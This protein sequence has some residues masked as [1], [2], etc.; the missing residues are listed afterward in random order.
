M[1]AILLALVLA[2]PPAA[3]DTLAGVVVDASGG[4]VPG[5][6]VTLTRN[7]ATRAVTTA[8]DGSWSAEPPAGSGVVQV[9]VNALGFAPAMQVVTLPAGTIRF[10]LRPAAIAEAI[11]VSAEA[12]ATR[13]AIESSV[14]SLDRASIATAPALRL[15]DQLRT[16]PGFSLFRRTS[17]AV[18]N[19]T[20]QGVTLRGL[21]ASGASRTLVM[22]DDV[23]LN[24]PFGMW[25]YW[26]RIPL[27]A[28]QRVDVMRGSSGDVHGNDALGGVIRLTTRTSR[29]AEAWLDAGSSGTGR[30]SGY[31]GFSRAAWN[32]GGALEHLTTNGYKVV[33]PE[34]RGPIDV[35]ADSSAASGY[36]WFGAARD[37]LQA[38][39][40]GGYFQEDRGNGTPAQVN[41]T[42]TRWGGATAHGFAA[43][44]VWE[45]RGDVS[46]TDYR[47]TFSAVLAGRASERLTSL[48][49][50][51]SSGGGGAVSWLRESG[52]AQMMFA[53]NSRVA[54]ADLDEAAFSLAGVL[55]PTVRTRAKQFGN[56]FIAQARFDLSRRVSI[57][58]GARA[59]RWQLEKLDDAAGENTLNFFSPRAGVSFHLTPDRTLRVAWLTGF[60]TP[61]M[62]ELYRGFRVGNTN[63]LANPA[64][65][66]ETSWGP[67]VAFTMRHQRWTARAIGYATRLE[68]AIYNRTISSTP[69][70]I[71]RERTNG[72][73][74]TIGSEIELEYRATH[75]IALTTSWAINNAVFTAGEL[76]G[77]R[78]P[79]V[80]RAAGSIGARVLFGNFTGAGTIRV[81]GMQFDDDRNELS[82]EQG[83]LTDL[84]A[85]W[86]LSRN[87]ELFG[88]LENTFDQE[89]DTG[90][91][92]IRTVGGPR[93]GRGGVIIK[94]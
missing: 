80:P 47:Q 8:A 31:A 25:V 87:L 68:G 5:A 85:G 15:D 30:A 91:T 1:I 4:S 58:A 62:N 82:L 33:A 88:A 40:R 90:R 6:V 13:L 73:A 18:A 12:S 76:D 89:I 79:Q 22:A 20:T 39:V 3:T 36:G 64:L 81:I 92:P 55:G 29:G 41:A 77:R 2:Q 9:R 71:V 10:Q 21:S 51:A 84:R 75:G 50:V 86:R 44:G 74:R 53:F 83:S 27:A 49:W 17:S 16:V 26:D 66:P 37:T 23:P 54:R 93:I 52:R 7:D 34:V 48:Q 45:A 70:A 72:E 59:D 67:E 19:P 56:G 65:H 57:D 94:F 78:V 42:I 38:T 35:P 32:T 28:L 69:T 60:R 46:L 63:T 61:T 11:T 43:G 24:D 14:T